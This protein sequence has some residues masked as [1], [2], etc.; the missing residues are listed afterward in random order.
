MKT[1]YYIIANV[2]KRSAD[3]GNS[4]DWPKVLAYSFKAKKLYMSE[5]CGHGLVGGE[6][7]IA[8]VKLADWSEFFDDIDGKWF[9]DLIL[10]GS[11]SSIFDESKFIELLKNNNC[12]IE[13]MS[14]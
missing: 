9:S 11:L 5:G 13:V 2:D 3:S 8:N 7:S 12:T 1:D 14:Y 10:N 4:A 6:I